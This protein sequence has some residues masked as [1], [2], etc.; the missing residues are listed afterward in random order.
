M[1]RNTKQKYK[2]DYVETFAPVTKMNT[3][4]VFSLAAHSRWTLHQFDVKNTLAP[5]YLEKEIFMELPPGL[6]Y[7]LDNI[8]KVCRMKKA[9]HG[10]KQSLTAWFERFTGAM[11]IEVIPLCS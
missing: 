9:P 10:L 5:E 11:H 2:I 8:N 6:N 1:L 7:E 4:R 3:V